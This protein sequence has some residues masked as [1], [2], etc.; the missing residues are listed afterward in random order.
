MQFIFDA[1]RYVLHLIN[2]K[3]QNSFFDQLMPLL[4]N[5]NLW[6]PLYLFV[7]VF[8]LVNIKKSGW[9]ILLFICTAALTD[10]LSSHVIK[11]LVFRLRPCRDAEM[12]GYIRVLASYCPISS[13]FTSSHAVNHFGIATFA[14]ITLLPYVG[15]W[16]FLTYLWAFSIIYAQLYVGVHYPIDVL[17]G[18]A[19]GVM[20]GMLTATV[21][22]RRWGRHNFTQKG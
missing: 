1:D 5:S 8:A 3:W 18:A 16:I 10:L 22:R 14:S 12:I 19:V 20:A 13:S 9:F 4:R 11:N 6:I 17:A 15:R 2:Y 7:G 21:Y